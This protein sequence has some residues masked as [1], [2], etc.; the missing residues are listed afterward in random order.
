LGGFNYSGSAEGVWSTVDGVNWTLVGEAVLGSGSSFVF[1]GKLWFIR[2]GDSIFWTLDGIDWHGAGPGSRPTYR[3][4]E[5]AAVFDNALWVLGGDPRVVPLPLPPPP[6]PYGYANDVWR[7]E[8]GAT[9]TQITA[10][11]QAPWERR[12]GHTATAF[13]DKLWL[14]GGEIEVFS[15]E[16]WTYTTAGDVWSMTVTGGHIE[17]SPPGWRQEGDPLTLTAVVRGMDGTPLYQWTKDGIPIPDATDN[18]YEIASLTLEDAGRYGCQVTGE[19]KQLALDLDPIEIQVFEAGS[20]P[21]GGLSA[22]AV[23]ALMLSFTATRRI[24]RSP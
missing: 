20:L 14:I 5:A 3:Y 8:D 6:L 11:G 4:R 22:M 9:W 18:P 12:I 1:D 16:G 23:L 10:Q 13:H 19:P 17:P 7:S 15:E 21:V 24:H 2:D